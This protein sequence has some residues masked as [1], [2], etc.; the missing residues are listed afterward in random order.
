M[1]NQRDGTLF[2]VGTSN[3]QWH[4][5]TFLVNAYDNKVASLAALGNQWSL[6]LE[7]ENLFRELLLS[8]NF[9]HNL[10]LSD[11]LEYQFYHFILG[12]TFH[13]DDEV[14]VTGVITGSS[15]IFLDV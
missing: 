9:I 8:Y 13:I 7:K 14:V 10:F 12:L 1:D 3:G 15:R 5:L 4:T 2:N 11:E 6:N